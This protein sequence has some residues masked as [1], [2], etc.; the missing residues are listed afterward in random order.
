M[1]ILD[2]AKTRPKMLE[3]A[4]PRP[5]RIFQWSFD[6]LNSVWISK[7]WK[8][9]WNVFKIMR[10]RIIKS[11]KMVILNL[12]SRLLLRMLNQSASCDC[13][14]VS[15]HFNFGEILTRFGWFSI[16]IQSAFNVISLRFH[17]EIGPVHSKGSMSV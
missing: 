10:S 14:L 2:I 5:R 1:T 17:S 9:E 7:I 11:F 4:N 12:R 13:S 15:F 3:M 16:Q 6:L 8:D